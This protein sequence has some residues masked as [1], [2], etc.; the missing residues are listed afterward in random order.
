MSTTVT[1]GVTTLTPILVTGWSSTRLAR[2]VLHD[3]VGT[4]WPEVTLR[5]AAPR[6]GTLQL[7]C[8]TLADGVAM[9]A[10]H[11]QAK[12]LTLA[13]PES[14]PLGMNYVASGRIDLDIDEDTRDK[15]IV[16]VEFKEVA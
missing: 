9:E 14:A 12:V 2:N 5:P 8:A 7:L 4:E 11:A 3:I 1:D 10:F 13:D 15:W 6:S 16:S